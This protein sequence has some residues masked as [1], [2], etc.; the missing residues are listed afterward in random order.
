MKARSQVPMIPFIDLAAQ[1]K[2]LGPAIDTA[3]ARVLTHCQFIIGPEVPAFERELADFAGARHAVGCASGTAAQVLGLRA[4][5]IGPGAAV[6]CPS[7]SYSATAE[8]A[9]RVGATPGFV[10]GD[11]ATFNIDVA[12][13]PGAVAAAKAA[14]LNPKAIIPVDLL[15]LL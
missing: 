2:R 4:L 7:V 10:D 14:G 8:V 1:R 12:G 11:A 3:V 6:L 5:G 9:V 13:I 15:G